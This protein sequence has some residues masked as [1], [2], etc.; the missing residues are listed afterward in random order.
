LLSAGSKGH[1]NQSCRQA[2]GKAA[3]GK[4]RCGDKPVSSSI[5][6]FKTILGLPWVN[7]GRQTLVQSDN[8]QLFVFP[9]P[10]LGRQ[11]QN[12]EK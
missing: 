10:L 3:P 6:C 9:Y 5:V 7:L 8:Y 2:F 12:L 11:S 1:C 4:L